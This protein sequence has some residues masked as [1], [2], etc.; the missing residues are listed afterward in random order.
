M[1]KTMD[2]SVRV[3]IVLGRRL[4]GTILIV[5]I[6]TFLLIVIAHTTNYFKS[7]FFEAI[8]TVNLTVMLVTP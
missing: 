4:L 3:T 7:F 5:Y 2:G 1:N 8:V 6:P